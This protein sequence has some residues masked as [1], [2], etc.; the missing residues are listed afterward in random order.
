MK[1]KTQ[2]ISEE[3]YQEILKQLDEIMKIRED[4][5]TAVEVQRYKAH[6]PLA[7]D[8]GELLINL[9]RNN[10][11][12]DRE[13]DL[14]IKNFLKTL[15]PNK[16]IKDEIS[17]IIYS[18][19]EM[20]EE[21]KEVESASMPEEFIAITSRYPKFQ[22]TYTLIQD[23]INKKNANNYLIEQMQILQDRFDTLQIQKSEYEK[24]NSEK[25]KQKKRFFSFPKTRRKSE[26]NE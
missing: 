17:S 2:Q 6:F 14:A 23:G 20:L 16:K 12:I 4:L 13:I 5:K 24:Q 8:F 15:P 18:R 1:E 22:T 7:E 10:H 11:D 25:Q 26:R 21:R 19:K 3:E 9:I